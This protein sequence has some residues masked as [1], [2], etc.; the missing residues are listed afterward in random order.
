MKLPSKT[1]AFQNLTWNFRV[2]FP[3]NEVSPSCWFA[4]VSSFW[5]WPT[6]CKGGSKVSIFGLIPV[7]GSIF[8][9]FLFFV[10]VVLLLLLL[11]CCCCLKGCSCPLLFLSLAAF[12]FTFLDQ[13]L[14]WTGQEMDTWILLRF[15][16]YT[17][18][19]SPD[20]HTQDKRGTKP[21][22][23]KKGEFPYRPSCLRPSCLSSELVM[24]TK[25]WHH[26]GLI[27]PQIA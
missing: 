2:E 18:T 12:Y 27:R 8:L 17:Q 23:S 16:L 14:G 3:R 13:V 5:M 11:L 26:N 9:L 25:C 15:F 1:V 4:H 21:K 24:E 7:F 20:L 6:E 22:H 10:V 19:C